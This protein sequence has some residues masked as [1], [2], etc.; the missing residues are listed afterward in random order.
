MTQDEIDHFR[1][2]G[3][4]GG[5]TTKMRHG[6]EYYSRIGKMGR[7][8]Q[9]SGEPAPPKQPKAPASGK[10]QSRLRTLTQAVQTDDDPLSSVM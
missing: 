8:K 4:E 10:R 7:A 9:L 6:P 2:M 5:V 3:R 1:V